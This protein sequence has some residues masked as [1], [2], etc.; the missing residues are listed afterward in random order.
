M[1]SSENQVEIHLKG[2]YRGQTL[3]VRGMVMG[4]DIT[5]DMNVQGMNITCDRF[6]KCIQR[7]CAAHVI[8]LFIW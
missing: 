3:Q 8:L 7:S 4:M 2:M 6:T 1:S 5:S